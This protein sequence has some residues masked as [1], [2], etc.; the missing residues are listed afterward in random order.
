ML[1]SMHPTKK[2]L[3]AFVLNKTV[4]YAIAKSKKRKIDEA[5]SSDETAAVA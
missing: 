2:L 1:K 3:D 5:S 4:V